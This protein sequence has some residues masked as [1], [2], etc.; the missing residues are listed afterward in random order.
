MQ[1]IIL[2]LLLIFQLPIIGQSQTVIK[3]KSEGGVSIIPCKVNGLPLDFIFDTGA[4]DVSISMTEATFMLKNGYLKKTDII[5]SSNY[6]DANGNI[7]EGIVI[8]L[9]EIEVAGLKI[10]DVRASIVKNIKAP[11]LL[12]QTALS[13][14][15]IIQLDFKSNTLTILH[16]KGTYDYSTNSPNENQTEF[17]IGQS[18]GGGKIFYIDN[19]GKHGLIVAPSDQS[20]G[21]FWSNYENLSIKTGATGTAIGTGKINT[22]KIIAS[23][24]EGGYAAQLCADLIL[25]GFDDWFLPS[26]DELDALYINKTKI[27]ETFTYS[28]YW[29]SSE[30][31]RNAWIQTFMDGSQSLHLKLNTCYVRAIR[32]F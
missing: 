5:G 30:D 20:K 24:G 16:G 19:T 13:K 28:H 2:I 31:K 14:L 3:M 8:N 12:G 7:N 29:S 1:N 4:D 17:E 10:T 26:K 15:G 23:L 32:A 27:G 6:L 25:N 18:Y 21:A 22:D 11:L 9:K